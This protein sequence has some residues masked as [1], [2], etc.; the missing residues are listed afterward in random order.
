MCW[1]KRS[2]AEKRRGLRWKIEYWPG[3]QQ[4]LEREEGC[5][6]KRSVGRTGMKKQPQIAIP[7]AALSVELDSTPGS[8]CPVS[9]YSTIPLILC[10]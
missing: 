6:E 3:W 5:V 1:S 4:K 10:F 9:Y 7:R 2:G 8:V